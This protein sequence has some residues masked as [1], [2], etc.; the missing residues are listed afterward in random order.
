MAS[1][2]L[3]NAMCASPVMA[4]WKPPS[5]S[6]SPVVSAVRV[7]SRAMVANE[8][9]Q[10]TAA[11]ASSDS[12]A[13][14][15]FARLLPARTGAQSR[16]REQAGARITLAL[17]VAP[18][19]PQPYRHRLATR[20]LMPGEA[21]VRPSSA[22]ALEH[23]P[24]RASRVTGSTRSLSSRKREAW[25]EGIVG[26]HI[27]EKSHGWGSHVIEFFAIGTAIIPSEGIEDHVIPAPQT[28]LD[29][30]R[31]RISADLWRARGSCRGDD[32]S[33]SRRSRARTSSFPQRP[34]LSAPAWSM[35]LRVA[36]RQV[37]TCIAPATA[38]GRARLLLARDGPGVSSR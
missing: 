33:R 1:S 26:V 38:R 27:E 5:L 11:A 3:I 36:R 22:D 34:R 19:E 24:N 17:T 6:P 4:L 29:R 32:F 8:S 2:W 10:R 25:A 14:T 13:G 23:R 21:G 31:R 20:S 7:R 16:F 9:G 18:D 37:S 30:A 35:R 15:A 12:F 28:V